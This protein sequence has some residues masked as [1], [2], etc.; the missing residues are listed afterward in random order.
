[1]TAFVKLLGLS[2]VGVLFALALVLFSP[3]GG[4][5]AQSCDTSG[6][7]DGSANP[8]TV[9]P[10]VSVSFTA[11]NMAAN[12]NVSFWFT[13]P[14]G[15]VAGTANPL[16]CAGPDGVVRFAPSPLPSAFYQAPGRWALTVEGANSHH[17][18]VIYF[19]VTT[20]A[21]P[22]P[23]A[24][25]VPPTATTAAATATTAPA[26]TAT[27]EATPAGTTTAVAASPTAAGTSLPAT[28]APTETAALL[29]TTP[30]VTE[31]TTTETPIT[32]GMPST[33]RSDDS[34]SL[35]M[36]AFLGLTLLCAGLLYRRG[37]D[38]RG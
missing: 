21:Q 26:G 9:L 7:R 10:G 22:E 6:S 15:A 33:G 1:M 23:T 36:I 3:A 29:P 27:T 31:A 4:A 18:S 38:A 8:T 5:S 37:L 28:A 11:T 20:Q 12:E 32:V 14:N 25:S 34:W 35:V 2:F 17:Q 16:C 30:P 13:L 19:C 24:T